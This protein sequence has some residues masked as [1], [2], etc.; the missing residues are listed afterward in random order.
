MI[1]IN[2]P[3]GY[4]DTPVKMETKKDKATVEKELACFMNNFNL[5]LENAELI[6]T[7]KDYAKV[8][9][10]DIYCSLLYVSRYRPLTLGELLYYRRKLEKID[11]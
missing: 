3:I 10:D 1:V 8:R 5:L 9:I 6:M 7:T 4:V 2:K 11:V